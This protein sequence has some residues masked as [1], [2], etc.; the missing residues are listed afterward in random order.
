MSE[1]KYRLITRADFDGI[2]CGTLFNELGI[3]EDTAFA[4]PADMQAGR[5]AVKPDDIATNLPYVDGVHLCFDHHVSEIERVGE[6]DNLVIDPNAPS[7]ARVVYDYYGGKSGFPEISD[8]LMAAV[9]QADSAQF[10]EEDIMAPEGW[11]LLNFLVDPATGLSRASKPFTVPDDQFFVDLMTYCRH[12]PIDEI[13]QIPDVLE[14]VEAYSYDAEFAEM[15]YNRCSRHDGVVVVTDLRNEEEII[16]V[17]RFL[18]YALYPDS[19]VS[20]RVEPAADGRV[21]IAAGKSILDRSAKA[22][23]GALMLEVAGGGGH[24]AAGAC[25]VEEAEVAAVIDG[26][27]KGINAAE[28]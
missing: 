2:V 10:S 11:T 8:E 13:M 4:E 17:N 28:N 20:V 19:K 27:V 6:R 1:E 23:I 16:P 22:N 5:V 15:Q 26:L 9:D 12:N 21:R 25:R 3:I 7:A 18:V 24:S 14:R